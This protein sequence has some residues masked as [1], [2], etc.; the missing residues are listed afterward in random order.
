MNEEKPNVLDSLLN[1]V[2]DRWH[3]YP[4][5]K[6]D[7]WID[8][9]AIFFCL[10]GGLFLIVA[11]FTLFPVF[12][13]LML[14]SWFIAWILWL[15]RTFRRMLWKAQKNEQRGSPPTSTARRVLVGI[16]FIL[17]GVVWSSGFSS[18]HHE[19]SYLLATGGTG[20]ILGGLVEI[21]Q[22]VK[23]KSTSKSK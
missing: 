12:L 5:T 1:N 10:C 18:L 20:L 14:G 11:L 22:A 2:F 19:W 15:W 6:T 13:G 4:R 9:A 17:A 23:Q 21:V 16:G 7:A 8:G 3:G